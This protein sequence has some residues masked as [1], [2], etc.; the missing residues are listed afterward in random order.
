MRF[1]AND[2][3]LNGNRVAVMGGSYGGY[4]VNA[5]LGEY[6]GVFDAG[7]SMVGVSDWV[8][9]LEDASPGLKASDRIEYG[10]IREERWQRFY[11]ENSPINNAHKITVP[12]LVQHGANDPRD[13]VT[14]SDRLV[15]AIRDAGGTVRYLRF[16]D[17][18]H[19]LAKRKNRVAFY[20]ELSRFLE[21]QLM[22]DDSAPGA[23]GS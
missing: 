13:P 17:E 19:S 2:E 7:V 14:E 11:E 8:R 5:V 23:D 4:M 18:G 15:K 21:E 1:L 20:R 10:D 16:P 6:P 12:L 3:R 22:P 9:A